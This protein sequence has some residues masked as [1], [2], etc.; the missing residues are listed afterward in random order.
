VD[1]RENEEQVDWFL[2]EH[3]GFER[4]DS[5]AALTAAGVTLPADWQAFNDL[6]DLCLRPNWSNTDGFFGVLLIKKD[7]QSED[8]V[9][10]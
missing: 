8:P 5:R 1:R 9:G 3:P 10:Q 7:P 6:G 2:S 4:A